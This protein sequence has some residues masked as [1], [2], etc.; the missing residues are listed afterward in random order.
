MTQTTSAVSS[1]RWDARTVAAW[2]GLIV[3]AGAISWCFALV[4][5]PAAPLLGSMIAGIGFGVAGIAL[6]MPRIVYMLAQGFAG[7][8]I[9][10]SLTPGI[11]VDVIAHSPLLVLFT[12]L[13]LA[14]AFFVGW[15]VNR[16]AG[17]P[18]L[19]AIFGSLPGMSGAMVIIAQERGV[20]GRI[21]A[22][23]QYTRLAGVI[24]AVSMISHSMPNAT[25]ATIGAVAAP[26]DIGL[27]SYVASIALALIG[28]FASRL[29]RLPAAAML[30]PMVL[31]AAIEA[32]GTF[33]IELPSV[34]IMLTFGIIGLEVGLKFTRETLSDAVRLVPVVL[35]SCAALIALGGL[36]A[37][38][39]R[40]M[41][42][43]DLL[44]AFLAMAPGSIETVAI[45]AVASHADVSVILTFQ[46]FRLFVVV[47]FGPALMQRLSRLPV[48]RA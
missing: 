23:M 13:T 22:L 6:R 17:V 32:T 21:V 28:P 3:L 25:P 48:W 8:F 31:G 39:L 37:L 7:V 46:T 30:V 33:Q 16:W 18:E 24:V 29:R 34:V 47:L 38:L 2:I 20:D 40:L 19:P 44:T 45:V 41:L 43:V 15:G 42:P 12:I 1:P 11:F 36:L 27:W 10:R 4:G 26:I 9:A 35:V 5:F 14:S